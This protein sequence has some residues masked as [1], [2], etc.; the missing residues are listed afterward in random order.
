MRVIGLCGRKRS[1][2]DT[3]ASLL[4]EYGF[5]RVA[6]A[7]RLRYLTSLIFDVDQALMEQDDT[8]EKTIGASSEPHW[9]A[10]ASERAIVH[11]ALLYSMFRGHQPTIHPLDHL[12]T[13]MAVLRTDFPG[14][15]SPRRLLQYMGT[16]W[17]RTLQ[18]DIWVSWALACI[19][20]LTRGEQV[21]DRRRGQVLEAS[22]TAP[23]GVMVSDVRFENEVRAIQ[24]VSVV[25][26]GLPREVWWIDAEK[27][28]PPWTP[29]HAS[30]PDPSVFSKLTNT[31]VNNNGTI[32]ALRE[33]VQ[34]LVRRTG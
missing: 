16:E 17:G 29:E 7:D 27:R 14:G 22:L 33:T 28:L 23:V 3:V 30:E 24:E 32:D 9:W 20:A 10:E 31:V 25:S 1:G 13:V 21:Y 4:G 12:R 15:V 26:R 5:V 19:E 18:G 11:S 2:K 6:F 34:G 8:K